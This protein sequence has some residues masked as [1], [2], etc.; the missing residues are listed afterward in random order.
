MKFLILYLNILICFPSLLDQVRKEVVE[1]SLNKLPPRNTIDI[2]KM[3]IEMSNVQKENSLNDAESAYFAYKWITYNIKYDCRDGKFG[4]ISNIPATIYKEG[5]GGVIG[6]SSL[7][8][9]ICG[10]FN[11]ES[12]PIFG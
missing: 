12:G 3:F 10:F 5:K 2:L 4:N 11:I 9:M 6:F 1:Q 8:N 7:F